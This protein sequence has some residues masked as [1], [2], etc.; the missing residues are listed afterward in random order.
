MASNASK[1]V[2]KRILT[3]SQAA[4]KAVK[5]VDLGKPN[6][7]GKTGFATVS[8]NAAEKYGSK[9]AGDRVAAS[10]MNKMRVKG[11]L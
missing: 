11:K 5:G 6:V 8:A 2:V 4:K 9:A 1:N 7:P 10:V 3:K